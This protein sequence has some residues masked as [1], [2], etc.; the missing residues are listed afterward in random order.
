MAEESTAIET[1]LRLCAVHDLGG[2]K[3]QE[4]YLPGEKP[5]VTKAGAL[6]NL[7][8]RRWLLRNGNVGSASSPGPVLCPM[9]RTDSGSSARGIS[10]LQEAAL[11]P[12]LIKLTDG[13]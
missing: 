11:E 4:K 10:S 9:M 13:L 5:I 6:E 8:L 12:S 3:Q 2:E 7:P 1:N